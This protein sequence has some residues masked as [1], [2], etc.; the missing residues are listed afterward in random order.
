MTIEIF[1]GS[2][3]D[4]RVGAILT[5]DEH[6]FGPIF[7]SAEDAAAFLDWYTAGEGDPKDAS[8]ATH[9]VDGYVRTW[10]QERGVWEALK[11]D[12]EDCPV[13][14]CR[15]SYERDRVGHWSVYCSDCYDGATDSYNIEARAKDFDDAVADYNNA[16]HEWRETRKRGCD[17]TAH[18]RC[19]G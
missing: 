2:W 6:P 10:R 13:C 1:S 8:F 9:A 5:D 7:D 19:E 14:G 11:R 16:V 12:A 3:P 15:P 17:E 4:G 18:Y